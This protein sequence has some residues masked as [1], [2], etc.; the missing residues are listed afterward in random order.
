[1][2]DWPGQATKDS[3]THR[4]S[5]LPNIKVYQK[6]IFG[7]TMWA[8]LIRSLTTTKVTEVQ[9]VNGLA[10]VFTRASKERSIH[11]ETHSTA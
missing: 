8:S 4:T 7:K 11:A 10:K 9:E 5:Y 6:T 1:M 2:K 3:K